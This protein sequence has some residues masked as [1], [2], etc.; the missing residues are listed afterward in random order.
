MQSGLGFH[1]YFPH[2]ERTALTFNAKGYWE[3]DEEQLP[4]D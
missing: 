3:A 1:P 2:R 4:T